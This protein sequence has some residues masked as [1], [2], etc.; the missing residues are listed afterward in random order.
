MTL[1]YSLFPDVA[2]L[3]ETLPTDG[4]KADYVARVCGAW[5]FGLVPSI[6]TFQL[7]RTWPHI[8]DHFRIT[9]SPSYVAFR[10][11]YGW[12]TIDCGTVQ[13]ARYERLDARARALPDAYADRT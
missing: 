1:D 12:P 6:E 10:T 4:D 9:G 13:T 5:D 11:L 2:E 8:F 3:P 7:L